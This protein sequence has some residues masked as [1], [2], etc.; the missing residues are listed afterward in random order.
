VPELREAA[1]RVAE[2]RSLRAAAGEIGI[3]HGGLDYFL[4]GGEPQE[5]TRQKLEAW[6]HN[7]SEA[8]MD[9]M[10]DLALARVPR[11]RKAKGRM[12]MLGEWAA[13]LRD[14]GVPLPEWLARRLETS[15]DAD[16]D[17]DG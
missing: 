16:E 9:A 4:G 6:Y 2:V 3:T 5:A 11:H 1:R 12:R 8:T 7:V 13:V 15:G 14:D 10:L 17:A